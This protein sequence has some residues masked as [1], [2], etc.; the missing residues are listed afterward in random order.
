MTPFP[1]PDDSRPALNQAVSIVVPT[2]READNL[3]VLAR[4]IDAALSG[5]GVE[6]ELILVD[7]DSGDG[8][9]EVA[10]KL[11]QHLPVRME[12][13]REPPRD[14]S[15]SV[16]HGIRI[17]RFDRIVVMDADLS[18]PP[19]R[20][21]DLIRVLDGECDMA[22]GS[23]YVSGGRIDQGWGLWRLLNSYG[24]TLLARPLADC[25]DPMSGFFALDRR[26]LPDLEQLRPVGYKIGLELMVRGRLR[27]VEVPIDF[28]D[29]DRGASKMNL[30]QQ[31][32]Y[33]RHLK[34]L[35]LHRFGGLA[36]VLS[37]GMVGVSG[38]VIDLFFYLGLQALG[39]EHRLARIVSF[40]PA[41][42]W[43]WWL[44]RR[45]TFDDRPRQAPTR[46]WARFVIASLV[47]LGVN[48]GSYLALT[49]YVAV[50][51]R[52]PLFAFFLGI[53]LGG[54]INFLV[55][56]LYVY[57]W[58]SASEGDSDREASACSDTVPPREE[59]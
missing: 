37:F 50:F 22:V 51:A 6:W 45:V 23:R 36:R 40:W 54:G 41:V 1:I 47:G 56:T 7:D 32:N 28:A 27:V 49:S 4:R 30:R 39:L 17:G 8:S 9:E 53:A 44:N 18:H 10:E 3:P 21:P 33:L 26:M 11:A 19:E 48:V 57:R 13:R 12:V 20:I 15:L 24:A 29:R 31:L 35:Y 2:F 46:Q 42:S 25:S 59:H 34:R 55:S 38:F 52:H 5:S 58:H 43:N 16:L 14:L